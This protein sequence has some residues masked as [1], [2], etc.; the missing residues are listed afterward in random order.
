MTSREYWRRLIVVRWL[1]SLS[2]LQAVR[3]IL[4]WFLCDVQLNRCQ[5]SNLRRFPMPSWKRMLVYS[6]AIFASLSVQ[7][8]FRLSCQIFDLC[9]Y[10]W[11]RTWQQVEQFHFWQLWSSFVPSNKNQCLYNSSCIEF[12]RRYHGQSCCHA[13]HDGMTPESVR[14]RKLNAT[15]LKIDILGNLPTAFS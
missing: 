12:H 11:P 2:C 3:Y 15:Q 8:C 1:F 9:I 10:P 14:D 7:W 5:K 4:L 6:L 13:C